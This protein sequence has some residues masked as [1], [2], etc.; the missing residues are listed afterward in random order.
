MKT[1]PSQYYILLPAIENLQN[2]LTCIRLRSKKYEIIVAPGELLFPLA[3][4]QQ[5]KFA[6]TP[7]ALN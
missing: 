7:N 6:L 2:E 5:G 4:Q 1:R 3:P